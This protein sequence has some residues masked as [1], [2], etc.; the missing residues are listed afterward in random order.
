Q[1]RILHRDLKPDN[2]LIR[3]E[4]DSWNVKII[5][6]GL[7]FRPDTIETSKGNN[8]DSIR[9]GSVAGTLKYAPPEQTGELKGVK[10]GPYSDVFAFGKTCFYALFK[11]TQPRR[12][13]LDSLPHNLA[14]LLED[15]I[16]QSVAT[17]L[18]S[19]DSVLRLLEI[20]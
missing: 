18:P 9:G 8:E 14:D 10:P 2:V 4:G 6:F 12:R 5:D 15:C 17:R 20:L 3:K 16:E 11:T 7:A 1:Q 13:Q 19:F